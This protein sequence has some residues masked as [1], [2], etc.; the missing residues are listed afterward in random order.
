MFKNPN[1]W[2]RATHSAVGFRYEPGSYMRSNGVEA[3]HYS[4]TRDWQRVP[5]DAAQV[6]LIH[7][8]SD[9][10]VSRHRPVE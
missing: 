2:V 3:T 7:L 6:A 4:F 9:V 8:G 5:R 10:E 1:W